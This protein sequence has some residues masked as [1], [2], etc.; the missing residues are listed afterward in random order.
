MF[1]ILQVKKIR[2]ITAAE[3]VVVPVPEREQ[4]EVLILPHFPL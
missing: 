2:Q 4:K 1:S 3:E